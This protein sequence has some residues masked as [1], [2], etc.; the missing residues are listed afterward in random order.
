MQIE[1]N[2][3]FRDQ[4]K[5]KNVRDYWENPGTVSL[6]DRNLKKLENDSIIPFLEENFRVL[7][8]GCGDGEGTIEYAKRVK[9]IIGMDYSRTMIRKS[10][11]RTR[12]YREDVHSLQADILS[13]PFYPGT[14]DAVITER[15]LINL[16]SWEFQQRAL[17]NIREVLKEGGIYLMLETT[18]QGLRALNGMRKKVGLKP[19]PMP[20]HN[21]NFDL[22]RL[23]PF[24]ERGF[25]IIQR[26]SFGLYYF[27]S[28]VIHPLLVV[29]EEPKY[30]AY[31]NQVAYFCQKA[32]EISGL[33]EAGPLNFFVLRKIR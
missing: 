6:M 23:L 32:F 29:P 10:L 8:I 14:F 25:Q 9:E 12:G 1:K 17:E 20:W 33:E 16:E 7:D 15:C 26:K 31:I 3:N 18:L 27:L 24:L 21:Q 19:I 28:R 13:L 2:L 5:S 22:E 30:D 4:N 11:G